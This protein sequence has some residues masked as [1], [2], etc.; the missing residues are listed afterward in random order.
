ML[1]HARLDLLWQPLDEPSLQV[2]LPIEHRERTLL[3]G[4]VGGGIVGVIADCGVNALNRRQALG[5]PV[6]QLHLD[7][8]IGETHGAQTGTTRAQLRLG[9]LFNEIEI[10]VH[11]IVKEPHGHARRRRERVVIEDARCTIDAVMH[12][13]REVDRAEVA[14]PPFGKAL[15]TARVHADD[16]LVVPGVC[17]GVVAVD[18]DEAGLTS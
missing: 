1:G 3:G 9:V 16:L 14:N 13:L 4:E 10:R 8:G 17:L 7:E 12:E 6:R 15:L 2:L 11:D 5:R 18:E